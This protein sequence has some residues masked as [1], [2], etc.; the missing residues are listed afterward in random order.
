MKASKHTPLGL[1]ELSVF[2]Y[3]LSLMVR[4]GI[5]SEESIGI[6]ADDARAPRQQ[7]LLRQV[8]D[9]LVE[10]QSLSS[11][12]E[13]TGVFPPYMLRMVEIG[14][15]SGRLD[16][17]LT[18]LSTFYRREAA[19]RQSLRRAIAYPAAMAVLIAVVFLALVSRVLPVFQQ[20]FSQLEHGQHPGLDA[21]WHREPV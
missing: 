16:Q 17:V 19:L 20:V 12:L 6:L 11:A 2:C 4:A 14:Q 10:G 1:D 8:H 15:I 9:V 21:V 18:A 5:G 7:A 3:Q 13:Q